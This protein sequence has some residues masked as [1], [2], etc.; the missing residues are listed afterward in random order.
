MPAYFISYDLNKQGQ[1]YSG[2][3]DAIKSYGTWLHPLDSTWL[4][5]TTDRAEQVF[6]KLSPH[7]DSND[8]ILIMEIKH[9]WHAKLDQQAY[10]WIRTHVII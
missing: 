1:D 6:N 10:D 5:S 8:R 7:I 2:L 4:I 3:F 9:H